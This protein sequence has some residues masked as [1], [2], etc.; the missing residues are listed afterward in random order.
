MASGLIRE[1]KNYPT[2]A[3]LKVPL[4]TPICSSH[5]LQTLLYYNVYFSIVWFCMYV[6]L[7]AWKAEHIGFGIAFKIISPIILALWAVSEPVRLIFGYTGNLKE[8]VP[9]LAAFFLLT[10]FPQIPALVYFLFV[11]TNQLTIN[12]IF[13]VMQ[14]SFLV[15]E[16]VVGWIAIQ[17]VVKEHNARFCLLKEQGKMFVSPLTKPEQRKQP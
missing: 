16:F 12:V 1:L 4:H 15:A 5:L 14:L 17:N 13:N 2:A 9:Q 7:W 8:K 11:E 10:A 3:G 6:P